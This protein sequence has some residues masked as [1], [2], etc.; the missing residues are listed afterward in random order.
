MTSTSRGRAM[1]L[2][3]AAVACLSSVL[4]ACGDVGRCE[5]GSPGCLA[6]PPQAGG[7]RFGLTLVGGA[8]AEPSATAPALSCQC[9]D[10]EV[11]TLDSYR[12]VDYCAPVEV[13]IGT[14]DPRK[15]YSCD[16]SELS[17]AELCENRCLIRCRQWQE[18]C[19]SSAGCGP[20]TCRSA[21]ELSACEQDCEGESDK[22]RCLA[23]Q[24][25][26]VEG[27][28]CADVACPAGKAPACDDVQCRN[29]CSGYNFDGICD[30]GDLKTAQYGV[31]PYGTDC[32][33]CGPRRG[34]SPKPAEQGEP[35]AFHSGCAGSNVDDIAAAKAWCVSIDVAQGIA[36]CAPDCS[37]PEKI[38]PEGSA[39]YTLTGIDRDGDGKEDP[40][41]QGSLTAAA[42]FPVMCK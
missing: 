26:D 1:A 42:C 7:C 18:L 6:G 19:P 24:C 40:I 33:D 16:A 32:A 28:A 31:C 5:R 17:F 25:S 22:K 8:C 9:E 21:A 39:C 37:L 23:Q 13:D 11:C 35:C 15:A 3:V 10:G 4:F 36:R 27:Q 14:A 30:D 41:A 20:D 2:A 12:C 29:T 38:C 34:P